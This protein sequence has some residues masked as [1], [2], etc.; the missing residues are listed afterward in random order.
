MHLRAL[1]LLLLV[2]VAVSAQTGEGARIVQVERAIRAGLDRDALDSIYI[3][4]AGRGCTTC[5]FDEPRRAAYDDAWNAFLNRLMS[6]M[7][8]KDVVFS[9]LVLRCYFNADGGIDY[10]L[11]HVG[12]SDENALRFVAAAE[13][14]RASFRF[15]E[16]ADGPFKQC[17]TIALGIAPSMQE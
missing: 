4:G 15:G 13:K 17:A 12:G 11:F 9:E 1:L 8:E 5:R 10:I 2:P 14:V 6:A 7:L 3:D 16:K